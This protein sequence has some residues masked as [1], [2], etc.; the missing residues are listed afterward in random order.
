[1]HEGFGGLCDL[2]CKPLS[3][4]DAAHLARAIRS[5]TSSSFVGRFRPSHGCRLHACSSANFTSHTFKSFFYSERRIWCSSNNL[6]KLRECL[7]SEIR[8]HLVR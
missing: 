1:V 3:L 2:R 5:H 6:S 7:V 8:V 4:G